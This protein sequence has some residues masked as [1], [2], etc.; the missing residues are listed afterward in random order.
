MEGCTE[1]TARAFKSS[2]RRELATQQVFFDDVLLCATGISG[3]PGEEYFSV[4]DLLD[5][6]NGDFEEQQQQEEDG[7]VEEEEEEDEKDSLSGSSSQ[8]RT[9]DIDDNNSNSSSLCASQSFL[10]HELVEPVDAFAELEWVSQFVDDSSPSELSLLYPSYGGNRSE[11]ELNKPVTMIKT[12]CCVPASVPSKARTKRTRPSGRVWSLGLPVLADSPVSS[13]SSY[14]W[15][16]SPS[17]SPTHEWLSGGGG[18]D[19]PAVKKLKR[20]PAVQAGGGLFQRRCSHCQIQKTPQWRTG[21]LGPKTL[22][23]ACGVRFKSGRLFPEYRPACSPTFSRDVH[24]NSHRKVLEM[25][26]KK[27]LA[28]PEVGLTQMVQSF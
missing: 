22:C 6:S 3:V 9:I 4:D 10:T 23:N 24:S 14:V 25:R 21:P 18:F 13:S 27:E 11:P 19:E 28:G 5:F 12:P 1:A 26:K 7:S 20:K 16:P 15:S 2:L 17:P 8:D